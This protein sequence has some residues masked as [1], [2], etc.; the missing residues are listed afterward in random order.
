[1]P[2][3]RAPS[4]VDANQAELVKHWR[5]LNGTWESTHALAGALDG[6]A[7]AWGID[8]RV[9]IKDGSKPPSARKLT[10]AEL[11]TMQNWKGRKPVVW[12]S[13]EDVEATMNTLH[14]EAVEVWRR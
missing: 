14:R 10:Q 1:M 4:R 5:G 3:G 13:V 11:T 2:R 8:V 12:E 6:I 7:G 9:E